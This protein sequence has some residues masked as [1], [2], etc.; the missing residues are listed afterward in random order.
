MKTSDSDKKQRSKST[1]KIYHPAIGEL[2]CLSAPE[3][4]V[5]L[6][7]VCEENAYLQE[8]ISISPGDVVIDAGA[9]IGV[10]TL[11]AAKRGAQVYS[12]EPVA[13]TYA[14]LTQNVESH[15]LLDKVRTHNIGLSDR[16]EEKKMFHYPR[17]SVCDA[18]SPQDRLLK[19][20]L[21]NWRDVLAGLERA[22]P[23]RFAAICQLESVSQQQAAVREIVEHLW[24]S[25]ETMKCRFD[26]LSK[27]IAQAK[28][29]AVD[30]LKLDA[31]LADW[32]ILNGVKAEDWPRIRQLAMEVH[33]MYD[34]TP[35]SKFLK[36]RDF[37]RVTSRNLKKG[38]S[39]VWATR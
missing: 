39:Y 22:D 7:E 14:V 27:A 34:V 26:T 10:F 28:L 3:A 25:A 13:P 21:E 20:M 16:R 31:E 19:Y 8:G 4:R 5:T 9:N 6:H 37:K 18:W 11:Y 17:L 33:M 12:Y 35:I 32:E 38:T 15:R 24:G 1:C 23:E 29:E 36:L 30:L 2:Y